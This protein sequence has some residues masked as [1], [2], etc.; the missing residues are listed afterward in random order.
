MM[1]RRDFSARMAHGA[2]WAGAAMTGATRAG[3]PLRLASAYP[4][5]TFHT[6][7][8]V[9]FATDV[10]SATQGRV[11]IEVRP[12]GELLKAAEIFAGTAD[13]RADLGE[14]IMSSL[15]KE[16]PVLGID[17]F[18]FIVSGYADARA[19]WDASK[20]TV[21]DDLAKR[22]LQ[23]LFAVPWQPQNLYATR[24]LAK[25]E[26]F[27]GLR[28]RYYNP[29]T[30]RIAELLGARPVSLAIQIA[31]L[32][33]AIAAGEFDS[34]ITSS[35]TGVATKA[36]SKM[37]HYYRINAWIPKNV[38]FIRRDKIDVL[39]LED[40]RSIFEAALR[41]QTRG[42]QISE[43][44][45]A[46]LELQLQKNKMSIEGMDPSMRRQLD[47]VGERLAREWMAQAQSSEVQVLS[48][49]MIQRAS[50]R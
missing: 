33:K 12:N 5:D 8:L 3:A 38:V 36:W 41:A 7:N 29:A 17:S 49:Y 20:A 16:F 24:P 37:T 50:R 47:R 43:E 25:P 30:L 18:P 39:P 6:V 40:R 45:N 48:S 15:S 22:G 19:L 31:Q 11:Q 35:W 10:A 34:M 27:K 9:A 21:T 26:D 2:T 1:T 32:E 28:M 44:S 42:W 23:M 13:G 46:D 14:V 4:L